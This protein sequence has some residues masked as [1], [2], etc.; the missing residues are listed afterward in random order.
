MKTITQYILPRYTWFRI[1]FAQWFK[2]P[3]GVKGFSDLRMNQLLQ[4]CMGALKRINERNKALQEDLK[5]VEANLAKAYTAIMVSVDDYDEVWGKL[6]SFSFW[7]VVIIIAESPFNYFGVDS[8]MVKQDLVWW[9]I[10]A[11]LALVITGFMII[12]F[13][14]LLALIIREPKYGQQIEGSRNW[15]HLSALAIFCLAYEILVYHMCKIR[16]LALEGA[17]G[18]PAI[19]YFLIIL[20][21]LL[22]VIAGYLAYQ[23]SLYLGAFNNYCRTVALE[24][25]RA[26]I[27]KRIAVNEQVKENTFKRATQDAWSIISEFKVYK[28][29]Y[30]YKYGLEHENLHAHFSSTHEAFIAEA[31]HRLQSNDLNSADALIQSRRIAYNQNGIKHLPQFTN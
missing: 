2:N 14:N 13:R 18:D 23:R 12:P 20:G 21:M 11:I 24:K 3:D 26:D 9:S 10:K 30:N 4:Q 22:P 5:T 7:L 17:N 19:T 31:G 28:A 15:G 8:L 25:K 16:G 1:W 6:R 29:N 27:L